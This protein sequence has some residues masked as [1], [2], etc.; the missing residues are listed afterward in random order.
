MG[1]CGQKSESESE[2]NDKNMWPLFLTPTQPQDY[3]NTTDDAGRVADDAL[4]GIHNKGN[5]TATANHDDIDIGSISSFGSFIDDAFD[6][7]GS[8]S[9]INSNS[10]VSNISNMSNMSSIGNPPMDTAMPSADATSLYD[11]HAHDPMNTCHDNENIHPTGNHSAGNP[12]GEGND[13]DSSSV[14]NGLGMLGSSIGPLTGFRKIRELANQNDTEMKIERKGDF[15]TLNNVM[16]K[17]FDQ[18]EDGRGEQTLFDFQHDDDGHLVFQN[19]TLDQKDRHMS[20]V[21]EKVQARDLYNMNAK[22]REA[23]SNEIHGVESRSVPENPLM[24]SSALHQMRREI[25]NHLDQ[26]LEPGKGDQALFTKKAHVRGLEL[27]SYYIQSDD[28]RL[29]FLRAELFDVSRAIIRYFRYLD[30]L[31]WLFG[32]KALKRPLLLSDLTKRELQYFRTGQHQLFPSRDRTGRRIFAYQLTNNSEY[33]FIER[34]RTKIYIFDVLAR[35]ETTQKIGFVYIGLI[36]PSRFKM[37]FNGNVLRQLKKVA[38][39]CPARRTAIHFCLP[40]SFVVNFVRALVFSIFD[41]QEWNVFRV[42]TGSPVENNYKLSSFGISPNDIPITYNGK[43]KTKNVGKFIQ[44]RKRIEMLQKQQIAQL[45]SSGGGVTN[46]SFS[47]C[48][49]IDCPDH[50]CVVFG[51]KSLYDHPA[52]VR[53]R[54]FVMDREMRRLEQIANC[55]TSVAVSVAEFVNGMVNEALSQQGG[56]QGLRFYA[57]EKGCSVY[58]EITDR[59]DLHKRFLQALRDVRKR[60]RDETGMLPGQTCSMMHQQQQQQQRQ[61]QHYVSADSTSILGINSYKRTKTCGD[62]CCS[63]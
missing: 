24:V 20:T 43:V 8:H 62:S 59:N 21:L 17:M 53:F 61:G 36:Q 38:M 46:Y 57:Y 3:Q 60:A 2:I 28:F 26:E 51:D 15:S 56:E 49:I 32:D 31:H 25:D 39:S 44:A 54:R 5:A 10:N 11:A 1:E 12:F 50:N 48:P 23:I 4:L 34:Q 18:W 14:K 6:A 35:D 9:F 16:N 19:K 7:G 52:N 22:E 13:T 58:H 29:R 40:N 47:S 41:K 27:Q 37:A 55:D 63:C 45:Q 33:S 30:V 42:H